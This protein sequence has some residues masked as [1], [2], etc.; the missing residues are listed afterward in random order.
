MIVVFS[1]CLGK[2]CVIVITFGFSFLCVGYISE[3]CGLL[4]GFVLWVVDMSIF[5]LVWVGVMLYV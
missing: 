5:G 2:R 3:W 4:F 1:S